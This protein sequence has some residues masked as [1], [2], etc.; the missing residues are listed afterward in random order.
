M[1][2]RNKKIVKTKS[3]AYKAKQELKSKGH[4]K[5]HTNELTDGRWVVSSNPPRED[6]GTNLMQEYDGHDD[7]H[8]F[9]YPDE[10]WD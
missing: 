7:Y 4:T 2:K 10:Y 1:G 8:T 3:L 6:D 9:G 5:V